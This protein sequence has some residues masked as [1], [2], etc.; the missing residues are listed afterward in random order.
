MWFKFSK[1]KANETPPDEVE[2]SESYDWDTEFS[3]MEDPE[4][5]DAD[6]RNP[7][8]AAVK[9]GKRSIQSSLKNPNFYKKNIEKVLPKDYGDVKT[10]IEP[11]TKGIKQLY[12]ETTKEIKPELKEIA[13]NVNRL[14]PAENKKIK[15]FYGKVVEK[16]GLNEETSSYSSYAQN[17]SREAEMA[18]FFEENFKKQQAINEA[19]EA[20]DSSEENIEKAID[21]KRFKSNMQLL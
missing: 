1:A 5:D 11:F 7:I 20:K 3:S 14:I 4:L 19:K 18:K 15:E 12:N 17:N 21:A 13:S 8:V 16:L 6:G 10:N 2:D 9:G